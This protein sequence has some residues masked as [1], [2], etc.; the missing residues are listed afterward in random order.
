V[1]RYRF[2]LR[3]KWIFGHFLVALLVITF[4]SLGF[5]QLR[6][7]DQRK[8]FNRLV[9]RNQAVAVVDVADL[10]LRPSQG[11]GH[12]KADQGRR[13]R[14][15]GE[16]LADRSLLIRGQSIDSTPGAWIVTPLRLADGTL[17]LI[18]RGFVGDNGALSQPPAA[19]APPA[20]T[21]TVEG[22]VQPTETPGV[23]EKRDPTGP[24]KAYQRID[25]DRIRQG[26]AQPTLPLWVLAAGQQPKDAGLALQ[27]VPPPSLN[28]GPHLSYAIQWFAFMLVGLIGYPLLLRR[29]ARD[30]ERG[31]DDGEIIDETVVPGA[32]PDGAGEVET[33]GQLTST[34]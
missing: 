9:L 32:G 20:G 4:I 6:R 14:V 1:H 23:F 34:S 24:L 33:N 27:P 7:L 22:S 15:T 31:P 21:V 18:N 11:T 3:P 25:I 28:N 5:W 2:A 13:V 29:K 8:A 30:L 16:Y 10:G 12:A 26:L 17:V 19:S